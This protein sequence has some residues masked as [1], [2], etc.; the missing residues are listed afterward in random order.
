MSG[1]PEYIVVQGDAARDWFEDETA[2]K[3]QAERLASCQY[4]DD[5]RPVY[6]CKVIAT[7]RPCFSVKWEGA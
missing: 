3:Q 5:A 1:T 6:V 2:A 4:P 7:A